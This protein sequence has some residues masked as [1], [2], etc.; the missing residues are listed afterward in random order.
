MAIDLSAPRLLPSVSHRLLV[1]LGLLLAYRVGCQIPMPGVD[2]S[3]FARSYGLPLSMEQLS[4]FALGVTPLFSVLV[5]FEFVKLVFP[6]LARWEVSEP[7][8]AR[9]LHGWI[10]LAALLAAAFQATGVAGAL[11]EVRGLIDAPGWTIPIVMTL[12]AA[13]ALLGWFADRIS[14]H[15][16]GNG[17][18]VLLIT[19]A[20]INLPALAATATEGVRQGVVSAN[21][22]AVVIAF[23]A[24]AIALIVMADNAWHGTATPRDPATADILGSRAG[25]SLR[26]ARQPQV[27]VSGVDFMPVW[28][29]LL[30]TDFAGFVVGL[31]GLLETSG[32]VPLVAA[33]GPVHLLILAGAIVAFLWLQSRGDSF[34][35]PVRTM[36]LVQIFV[37]L[38]GELLTRKLTLPFAVEGIWLIIV[39]TVITSAMRNLRPAR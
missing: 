4:I 10:V 9:R 18:W 34:I 19:P 25:P 16:I 11:Y 21:A 15:G 39:V 12:V 6:S 33:G 35:R 26:P 23:L 36:A 2:V 29:A 8:H 5:I 32:G 38:G 31:L 30:G 13:T 17:F 28:P 37:C 24:I 7:G 14:R 22:L 27:R 3:I 20:L 1:T